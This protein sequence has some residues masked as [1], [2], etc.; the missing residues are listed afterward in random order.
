MR[1]VV[2]SPDN[3]IA[4]RIESVLQKWS[5]DCRSISTMDLQEVR[6]QLGNVK[7]DVVIAVQPTQQDFDDDLKEL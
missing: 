7:P 5:W 1:A 6:K 4:S 3:A 2:I